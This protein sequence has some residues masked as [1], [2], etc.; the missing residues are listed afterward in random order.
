MQDAFNIYKQA[1]YL[2]V[3]KN[4][5]QILDSRHKP[6]LSKAQKEHFR[7]Q[8]YEWKKWGIII[9]YSMFCRQIRIPIITTAPLAP[10][11]L[12]ILYTEY[13]FI[14]LGTDLIEEDKG[15]GLVALGIET[16]E[17]MEME[18]ARFVSHFDSL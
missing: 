15:K 1:S 10:E 11:F 4:P 9:V 18:E 6:N 16:Q 2:V 7:G 17:D 3:A 5:D 12:D 8:K 13:L 14:G